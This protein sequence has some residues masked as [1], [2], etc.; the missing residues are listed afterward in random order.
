MF[1]QELTSTA[2]FIPRPQ[3]STWMLWTT[4]VAR[5]CATLWTQLDHS[6]ITACWSN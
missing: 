3:M 6:T 5:R 1:V 2:K 4:L